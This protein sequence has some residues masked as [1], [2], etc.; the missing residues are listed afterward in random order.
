MSNEATKIFEIDDERSAARLSC[1]LH[2]PS[3]QITHPTNLPSNPMRPTLHSEH[4][5]TI[6]HKKPATHQ[7]TS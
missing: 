3:S 5:L 4:I 7:E 1:L 2:R 6:S